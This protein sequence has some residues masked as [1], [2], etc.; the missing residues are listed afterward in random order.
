[1]HGKI[2]LRK[3]YLKYFV[4]AA[5][6][7]FLLPSTNY[8]AVG[9][10]QKSV[11]MF[12]RWPDDFGSQSFQQSVLKAKAANVNMITL[13][14]TYFQGNLYANSMYA[15][16][17]TPT[18]ASLISA[19]DFIHSQ[20]MQVTLS[21]HVESQDG[22]W[23]AYINPSDRNQW[24]ANYG[25]NMVHLAQIGQAHNVEQIMVGAELISLTNPA[26][27]GR[28]TSFWQN[29]ISKIRSVY[30]GKLTYS[31]NWGGTPEYQEIDMVQ[32]WP[33][34]DSIGISAYF[35]LWLDS[36]GTTLSS[37]DQ[38]NKNEI[39]PLQQRY[40]KPVIFTEA[41]YRSMSGAYSHPWDGGSSG[42]YDEG[43]QARDY[44]N[45]FQYWNAY[46][47]MNGVHLWNWS[48]DPNGEPGTTSFSPQNK[49]AEGVMRQ[50]FSGGTTPLPPPA[51]DPNF[52]SANGSISPA[53][54]LPG[55]AS[56]IN[57]NIA[58]GGSGGS[59]LIV[60]LEVYD[61]NW[62]QVAQKYF[63]GQNFQA[64]GTNS[65]SMA[66]T[67]GGTGRYTVMAGVF[68]ADW[69]KNYYWNNNVFQ[70]NVSSGSVTPPPT[71]SAV[72]NI[73]WPTDGSTVQGVQPF[74]A[75]LEN[76]DVNSYNMYWQVDGGGLVAMYTSNTNYPHKEAQVD[77]SGWNWK[78]SGP[79]VVTFVA[80]SLDNSTILAQKSSSIFVAH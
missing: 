57:V 73:W 75:V 66:W 23:R 14:V 2:F 33:S 60:D 26:I 77:L 15:G 41:G 80:K 3:T 56:T 76:T 69:S 44:G 72:M 8:A 51:A 24:F 9:S 6:V 29:L 46:N 35:N 68:N 50:W 59:G 47:F 49:Q 13:I 20:G 32:F 36:N 4:L 11:N 74:L 48:T 63:T 22:N 78:G 58:A 21:V 5:I 1:M 12:P 70:F 10:W 16:N 40:G 62:Q 30:S 42:P 43:E 39:T 37:W 52:T 34:L 19:I 38:W 28:N 17:S 54:P 25:A 53:N 67:S 61:S 71:T 64:N 7:L 18:D 27:D 79:Y 45:L 65:Y 31:A 55:Q